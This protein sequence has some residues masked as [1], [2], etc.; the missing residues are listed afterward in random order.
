MSQIKQLSPLFLAFVGACGFPELVAAEVVTRSEAGVQESPVSERDLFEK[1]FGKKQKKS[2]K[3]LVKKFELPVMLDK[4][5]VGQ[6][7]VLLSNEGQGH[8]FDY[9]SLARAM[10]DIV[11]PEHLEPLKDKRDQLG[12]LVAQ[13]F[14][15]LGWSLRF[16][17]SNVAVEADIPMSFRKVKDYALRSRRPKPYGQ[18]IEPSKVSAILNMSGAQDYRAGSVAANGRQPAVFNFQ[19]AANL[20]SIVLEADASYYEKAQR[21]WVRNDTRLVKDW[22]TKAVRFTLGDMHT[23]PSGFQSAPAMGGLSVA[24][25]FSIRPYDVVQS[26]GTAAFTLTSD[27]K[28]EFY[29]NDQLVETRNLP[30]GPYR[31]SDFPV[32]TGANDIMLRITDKFGRVEEIKIPFFYA[33]TLLA[34]GLHAFSYNLGFLTQVNSGVRHYETKVPVVTLSHSYGLTS[35]TTIGMNAQG[36]KKQTQAGVESIVATPLGNFQV[37]GASSHIKETSKRGYAGT[38]QYDVAAAEA[39]R[40]RNFT[41]QW[42]VFSKYFSSLATLEPINTISNRVSA[43]YSQEIYGG[44][45]GA[46]SSTYAFYRDSAGRE[47]TQNIG[48]SKSYR[49]GLSLTMDVSRAKRAQVK[50]EKRLMVGLRWSIP[51]SRHSVGGDYQSHLNAKRVRWNYASRAGVGGFG[52]SAS[53]YEA[54]MEK[55]ADAHLDYTANRFITSMSHERASHEG[56]A[57]DRTTM[58]LRTALVLADGHVA[59]SRPVN[60]SFVIVAPH[61]TLKDQ[62]LRINA[63]GNQYAAQNDFLG[64]AVLPDVTSYNINSVSLDRSQIPIGYEVEND[65]YYVEPTYRRGGVVKVGTDAVVVLKGQ[66]LDDKNQPLGLASGELFSLDEPERTSILFFTNRKGY[67]AAE[68]LKPGKYKVTLYGEQIFG[69]TVSIPEGTAGLYDIK[70]Q[71]MRVVGEPQ[72]RDDNEGAR[73]E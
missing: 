53:A 33:S 64:S 35:M 62:T 19:G 7:R 6:M 17:E 31:L 36:S 51:N 68:G 58:N 2:A 47:N 43:R 23:R 48:L 45:Y 42:S 10:E 29:V 16:D 41:L 9:E 40:A 67:Y 50:T 11:L 5:S 38:L 4:R 55:S 66:L 63:S 46:L 30:S 73:A 14:D 54:K 56:R 1:T 44:I 20:S 72:S 27:S 52:A 28:V 3:N 49:D 15:G 69:M 21:P 25:D 12:Y 32:S 34:E 24:R 61:K 59:L 8:R 71:V 26:S 13:D 18:R 37:K 65:S 22:Q 60:D 39:Q 57:S 70:A